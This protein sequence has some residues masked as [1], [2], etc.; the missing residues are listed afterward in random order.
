MILQ[1]CSYLRD[2]KQWAASCGI[3]LLTY[4]SG[5]PGKMREP[6]ICSHGHPHTELRSRVGERT[7]EQGK[8]WGRSG[9]EEGCGT[10]EA[11]KIYSGRRV[12]CYTGAPSPPRTQRHVR[13]DPPSD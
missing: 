12:R 10:Q 9:G 11:G 6:A 7:S 5:S 13:D 4:A 3:A 2:V 8:S 1:S